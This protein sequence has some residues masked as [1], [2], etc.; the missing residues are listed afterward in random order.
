MNDLTADELRKS[1]DYFAQKLF[2][3]QCHNAVDRQLAADE[4]EHLRALLAECRAN[5]EYC[6][7]R[8]CQHVPHEH[9]ACVALI[10]R[11]DAAMAGKP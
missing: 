7:A 3:T 8:F 1:C 5:I 11:I 6:A 2:S 4:I 10:T 9:A